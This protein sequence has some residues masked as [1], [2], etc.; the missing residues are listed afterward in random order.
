[1][2]EHIDEQWEADLVDMREFSRFN[3]NYNYILT[4]IDCFSKYA[5]VEPI[6]N[7]TG[8]N[9]CEAFTNI[10]S[11]RKPVYLRTDKGKEFL[12]DDFQKFL[13]KN[14]IKH[15]T[16]NDTAIKC[17]IVE[18]FNR[19]L[20]G[21]MFKYFTSIGKR[22]YI[23]VLKNFVIAYNSAKHRSI[24]MRPIDVSRRNQTLLFKN[25]YKVDSMRELLKKR[26]LTK[27]RSNIKPGDKVRRGYNLKVFDRGFYPNYTDEVFTVENSI[28]GDKSLVYRIKD[29]NGKI[30][31]Q[32][33]Y[34][35]EIQKISEN[36]YRIEK[37]LKK[38]KKNGK[39]EYFVKWLNYT[40]KYNSWVPEE[41]IKDIY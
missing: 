15:F 6:K 40:E 20:K 30:I 2:V 22:R 4:V 3:Y 19:T 33:F 31:E 35:E 41:D 24:K 1:M 10:F 23:D 25:L 17:A 27:D 32:R 7:K 16:S 18:R 14:G 8:K 34:P 9:I 36:L 37:V 5:F 12:N 13:D 39:T 38:R 11:Q 29:H 28:K 26:K 21:R